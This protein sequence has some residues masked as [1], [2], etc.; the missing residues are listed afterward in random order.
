[1]PDNSRETELLTLL[2]AREEENRRLRQEVASFKAEVTLL[3][4]ENTLL[5]Q[6]IDLLVRRI[7]GARSE[8]SGAR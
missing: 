7:F 8:P 2:Q 6:K 1:M 4:T 5:R 3:K